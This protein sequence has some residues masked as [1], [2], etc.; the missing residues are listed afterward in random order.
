MLPSDIQ[1]S[2][3]P[4]CSNDIS[5]NDSDYDEGDIASLH[6]VLQDLG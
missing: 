2:Y 6:I 5:S 4:H 3:I 1:G